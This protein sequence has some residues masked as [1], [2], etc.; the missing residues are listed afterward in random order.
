MRLRF[1]LQARQQNAPDL[2]QNRRLRCTESQHSPTLL[3]R[4]SHG[5][6]MLSRLEVLDDVIELWSSSRLRRG[7]EVIRIG[8]QGRRVLRAALPPYLIYFGVIH[9]LLETHLLCWLCNTDA[10]LRRRTGKQMQ[11]G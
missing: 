7:G 5:E 1:S 8:R 2:H 11:K 3:A 10:V 9:V 6:V 4:S